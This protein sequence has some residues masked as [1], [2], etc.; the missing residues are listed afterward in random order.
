MKDGKKKPYHDLTVSIILSLSVMCFLLYL[1]NFLELYQYF[2]KW[3]KW[4]DWTKLSGVMLTV[5]LGVNFRRLFFG[6]IPKIKYFIINLFLAFF[7]VIV[8]LL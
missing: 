7:G 5:P 8:L 2:L 6:E 3:N 1:F 4:R